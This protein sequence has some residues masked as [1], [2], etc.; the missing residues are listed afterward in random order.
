MIVL[1]GYMV[2]SGNLQ[3]ISIA[4]TFR[5]VTFLGYLIVVRVLGVCPEAQSECVGVT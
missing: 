3:T 1:V 2:S 4:I 5:I